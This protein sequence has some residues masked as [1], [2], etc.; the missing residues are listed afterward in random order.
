MLRKQLSYND[1]AECAGLHDAGTGL[2]HGEVLCVGLRNQLVECRI[3]ES[4]PPI[5][6]FHWVI[7]HA[8]VVGVDPILRH[9]DGGSAVFRPHLQAVTDPLPRARATLQKRGREGQHYSQWKTTTGDGAAQKWLGLSHRVSVTC[10]IAD[11]ARFFHI[12]VD[13]ASST[14]ICSAR[15]E[16]LNT[17]PIPS[18][19]R[20]FLTRK[21]GKVSRATRRFG[22]HQRSPGFMQMAPSAD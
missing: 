16:R 12:I 22:T 8:F 15:L 19:A 2:P 6:G 1:G 17:P 4:G 13:S 11:K 7:N 14:T 10:G 20:A 3:I 9:R 21:G 5:G 18:P